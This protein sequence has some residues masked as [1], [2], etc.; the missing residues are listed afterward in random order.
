[1]AKRSHPQFFIIQDG[2]QANIVMLSTNQF[3]SIPLDYTEGLEATIKA[4]LQKAG[5][6]IAEN[7]KAFRLILQAPHQ[8]LL[9]QQEHHW[10]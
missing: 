8:L 7:V 9:M 2:Q 4:C 3:A 10:H 5:K 1:M 6:E